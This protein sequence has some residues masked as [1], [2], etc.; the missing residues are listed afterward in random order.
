M[1]IIMTRFGP[2]WV[3]PRKPVWGTVVFV[4]GP[5]VTPQEVD[6]PVSSGRMSVCVSVCP[7]DIWIYRQTNRQT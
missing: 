7:K 6:E 5:E 4:A 3:S 1:N 2:N